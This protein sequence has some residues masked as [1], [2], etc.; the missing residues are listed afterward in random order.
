[1]DRRLKILRLQHSLVEPSDHR[2]LDELARFPELEVRALCPRWGIES[3]SKRVL[4]DS[5]PDITVGRTIFTF[6]YSTTFF[7]S[8]LTALIRDWRPDVIDLHEEPWSLAAGQTLLYRRAFL[9]GARLLGYSAQNI[10]KDY[11]PPFSKIQ[12]ATIRSADVFYACSGGVRDV[13]AKR[14][15]G[16]RIDVVP[17]GLDPALFDYRPHSG[18]LEGRRLAAGYVGRMA[19]EKGIFTLLRAA[20][21]AGPRVKLVFVGPG[22]DT[23]KA[24]ALAQSLGIENRVEFFGG[25]PR[26]QVAA[27]MKSFDV[28]VVPSQTTRSWKEQFGRVIAEA[29][30]LG[31]PVI[32]SDSGAIPET[33]GG[34]GLVFPEKDEKKLAA[35]LQRLL[36]APKQLA[37][38]SELGRDRVMRHYTWAR[39]AEMMR[40]LY[41]YVSGAG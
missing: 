7:L 17:L 27:H 26:K 35:L 16:G 9:P 5:R 24:Q 2:L 31:V 28:L 36:D 3:G 39:V 1:M 11:P 18:R 14:G 32:G 6:N 8:G 38:M 4:S 33:I 25:V 12:E 30:C 10:Y 34:A 13:I 37:E 29:M 21:I 19:G 22:P 40:E 20:A 15:F 41:H 23:A